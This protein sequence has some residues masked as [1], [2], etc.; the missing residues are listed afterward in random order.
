[1]KKAIIIALTPVLFIDACSSA[2]LT[3][4]KAE[5]NAVTVPSITTTDHLCR[6][7]AT[8][9]FEKGVMKPCYKYNSNHHNVI[10][11]MY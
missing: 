5:S 6:I 11:I 7:K 1:M 8:Q 9:S 2:H 4:S 3:K 10:E